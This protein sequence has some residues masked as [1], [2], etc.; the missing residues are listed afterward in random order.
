MD[1]VT[2]ERWNYE[3][4]QAVEDVIRTAGSPLAVSVNDLHGEEL[5][6]YALRA[7]NAA[8]A[9][10]KV[11]DNWIAWMSDEARGS[12]ASW[13]DIGDAVGTTRQAA[14]MRFGK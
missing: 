11:A 5:R 12:G 14:Q 10:R 6:E 7:L 9:A 3:T 13:Q 2:Q 4:R 8:V 1:K